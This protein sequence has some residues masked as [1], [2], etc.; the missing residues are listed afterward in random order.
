M[1]IAF[2]S[3]FFCKTDRYCIMVYL[4]FRRFGWFPFFFP[5]PGLCNKLAVGFGNVRF[6]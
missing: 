6:T 2:A 5:L 4:K 3:V 1:Y